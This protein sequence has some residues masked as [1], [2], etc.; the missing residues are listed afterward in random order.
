MPQENTIQSIAAREILD[1]RGVPTVEVT[2]SLESGVTASASVPSGTSTGAHEVYELR[3][4]VAERYRG[5]GVIQACS[6]VNRQI[7]SALKGFDITNQSAIDAE[8]KQLDGT[9]NLRKLGANAILGVSLA[10]ARTAAVAKQVPL[11]HYL[12]QLAG[13]QKPTFKRTP[14]PLF[15]IFNGGKHADTNLDF[16]EFMI[17]P[18]GINHSFSE[19]L[20]AGS[21]IFHLL[22]EVLLSN[23]LDTD[24]G[25]EG[26]YAPNIDNSMQALDLIMEAVHKAGYVA[27]EQ[28]FLGMDVGASV[29]FDHDRMVYHFGLLDH[30]MRA[31]QLISLYEDWAKKYPFIYIEDGLFEDDWEHWRTL[32]KNLKTI[33]EDFLIAGDDLFVTNTQRLHAGIEQQ[34]ANAVIVKPNQVGTLSDTLA[35]VQQAKKE[36]YT[37]I[38]SHRSGETNDDFISDLAVGVDADYIKAGSLA[39]GERLAKY[40]R[41]LAIEDEIQN[42][43]A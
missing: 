11:Y 40:N 24:V 32:T 29:L 36:K 7:A 12:A 18:Q 34:A 27:G 5:M 9:H 28:I 30:D 35:F 6:N 2:V 43:K 10:C 16:Q 33:R 39:R 14:V 8:L 41:L 37:I 22:R 15:N 38:I 25:I 21:E 13:T 20:R 1:S 26:G 17:I 31:E 4:G 19:R 42:T 23:G 3:D